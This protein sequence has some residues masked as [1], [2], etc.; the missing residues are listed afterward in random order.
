MSR[1]M[2]QVFK[3][4]GQFIYA[5]LHL[6]RQF[7]SFHLLMSTS[8]NRPKVVLMIID[9]VCHRILRITLAVPVIVN[10]Q[11]AGQPHQPVRKVALLRI[12]LIERSVNADENF[13]RQVLGR[14][15][16]RRK[17]VREIEDPPRKCRNDIFPGNAV[18]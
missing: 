7:A 16:V 11:I 13:L 9:G 12:V 8:S 3:I 18:A 6:R 10:Y 4:G 2:T 17:A 14:L 5:F 1:S 15:N